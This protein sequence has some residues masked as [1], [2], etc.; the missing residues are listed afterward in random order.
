MLTPEE[1]KFLHYWE[2]SLPVAMGG[3]EL[4]KEG[5]IRADKGIA[6]NA[7]QLMA[8]VPLPTSCRVRADTERWCR[9]ASEVTAS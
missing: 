3:I 2:D 4:I 9:W 7:V 5:K 8:P 1:E 6:L